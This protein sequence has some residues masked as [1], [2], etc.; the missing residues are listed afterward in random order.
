M[1]DLLTDVFG[2]DAFSA[3]S[4]TSAIEILG[5]SDNYAP[6]RLKKMGLFVD[7]GVPTTA[8]ALEERAGTL[9]LLPTVRRGGPANVP[10]AAK[11][12][13]RTLTVPHIPY[14]D[15]ILADAILNVRKFGQ[16]NQLESI[17]SVVNDRLLTMRRDHEVTLERLK[18]G[19]LQGLILDADDSTIYS[20]FD[21]FE[22]TELTHSFIFTVATTNINAVLLAVKRDVERALGGVVGFDHI[23]CLAD[24]TW[25]AAFIDHDRVKS[26]WNYYNAHL[27]SKDLRQGFEYCGIVFEE[28][29]GLVNSK[30][31][32]KAST[33]RFFP[34]GVPGLFTTYYGPADFV[35]AVGTIGLPIYAKQE[36]APLGRGVKLHVQ[37][38]PLPL[39]HRPEC[40]VEGT[41]A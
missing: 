23:H 35:E 8:I 18:V 13:M 24:P 21:E 41:M 28:Y 9:V 11:R 29:A 7:K 33:A 6:T 2:A 26:A 36:L 39:C 14:E 16:T 40:C 31:F 20:L 1:P 5:D 27:Q 32:I 22:V 4:L 15:L 3:M 34:V 25:F 19:A 30:A 12:T 17:A 37:S 38:N 10:E